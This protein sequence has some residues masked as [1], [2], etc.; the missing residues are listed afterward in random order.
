MTLATIGSTLTVSTVPLTVASVIGAIKTAMSA[1]TVPTV[2]APYTVTTTMFD[3]MSASGYVIYQVITDSTKL[4]GVAY[5]RINVTATASAITLTHSLS[6]T[7]NATTHTVV[8]GQSPAGTNGTFSSTFNINN[9]INFTPIKHP[10][11]QLV[12]VDQGGTTPFAYVGWM[13]PFFKP[14]EC[15]E[16]ACPYLFIP[17]NEFL[18]TYHGVHY[19][20]FPFTGAN[21]VSM[22]PHVQYQKVNKISGLPPIKTGPLELLV[23]TANEGGC[24]SFSSDLAIGGCANIPRI[25]NTVTTAT[26][27]YTI[28]SSYGVAA[29][30]L[31]QT[32]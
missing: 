30:L 32:A 24:G 10:E 6:D 14:I 17:A 13:R 4:K 31:I 8:A 3:D 16:S 25:I 20:L 12:L 21:G 5:L 22:V 7:W 26:G 28:L 19:N 11:A 2:A 29:S 18:I 1:A 23:L 27:T 15:D 9:P